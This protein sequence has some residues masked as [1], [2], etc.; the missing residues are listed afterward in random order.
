MTDSTI[1]TADVETAASALSTET[2]TPDATAAASTPV[3]TESTTPAASAPATETDELNDPGWGQIP[4]SRRQS[5]L[6]N[7]RRKAVTAREAELTKEYESKYG[8]AKDLDP[9]DAGT[10]RDWVRR[11]RTD[12]SSLVLDLWQRLQSDPT[13]GPR[14]RSEAARILGQRQAAA[15]AAAESA[16]AEPP[17]DIPTDTSNG[18]P[19]VYSA[20]QM[21]KHNAWM[22]RQWMAEVN[23]TLAPIQ[24]DLQTRQQVE[25]HRQRTAEADAYGVTTV[26]ALENQPGFQEHK[27]AI[28]NAYAAM[29]IPDPRTGQIVPDPNDQRTEGEKLRDAYLQV[30][31]PTLSASVRQQTVAD[32]H[33]KANASTVNPSQTHRGEPFDYKNASWE[34]ALRYEWDR[35][36]SG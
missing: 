17:P 22:K 19:V 15:P 20:A 29:G 8:W 3:S 30:V 31:V 12:P 21:A 11:G 35:R 2:A 28:A 36:K 24:Q 23:Q 6:D 32:L 14:L 27:A 16:D 18:Q 13:H 34:D 1:T 4:Q 7:A 25:E 33:R 26:K 5:I 10:V 9:Q